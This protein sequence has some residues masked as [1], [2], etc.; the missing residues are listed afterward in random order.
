MTG[1][2]RF[3]SWPVASH[4]T[5]QPQC[6][7]SHLPRQYKYEYFLLPLADSEDRN[8]LPQ[9]MNKK[10]ARIKKRKPLQWSG[11][12]TVTSNEREKP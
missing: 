8:R 5:P 1:N 2:W 10:L 6:N 11:K 7:S 3:L 9:E 4:Q 12:K